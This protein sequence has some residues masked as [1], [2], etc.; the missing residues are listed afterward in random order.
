MNILFLDWKCFL[1]E[2]TEKTMEELGHRV[3]PFIEEHYEERTS[4][5]F[6]AA[7]EKTVEKNNIALCFSYNFFPSLAE[8]CKEMNIPYVSFLYDSPFVKLFSFTLMYPTNTVYVFDSSLAEFF[9]KGGITNV[10]YHVLPANTRKTERLKD[11]PHGSSFTKSDVSFIGSLY[12]EAHNFYDRVD[13][14]KDR[15]L[16]GYVKGIMKAQSKIYG[17]SILEDS[18]T[19]DIIERFENCL[20]IPKSKDGI[21]SLAYTYA[22]YVLARKLTSMERINYL[23]KIGDA[24]PDKDLKLYTLSQD[25]KIPGFKTMGI[26]GYDTDM[27][28]AFRESRINLNISLRSIINGIPLR[29][30]DIL[31]SGGFLLSNYQTDLDAAFIAGEDYDYF[32]SADSLVE[33]IEYYLSHENERKEITE[34]GYRK[35]KENFS[36]K[37]TFE[38][39]LA[40]YS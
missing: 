28:H 24:F 19:D 3:F 2:D 1:K 26:I 27:L 14:S 40:P 22:N 32:D 8:G 35:A 7:F 38:E 23:S 18:L 36:I 15:Y 16:E 29:A 17:A 4:E 34:N 11:K 37:K 39:I 5:E 9:Q 13:F 25:A 33:K 20:P 6:R 10:H 31:A 30:M 21:D 12:N